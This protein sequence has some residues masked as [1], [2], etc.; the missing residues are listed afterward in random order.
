ACAIS[1]SISSAPTRSAPAKSRTLPG[2][3]CRSSPTCARSL[4]R[5]DRARAVQFGDL[6][7]REAP[8][9]Q[10][11]VGVLADP[12]RRTLHPRRRPEKTRRGGGLRNAFDLD[13]ALPVHIV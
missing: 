10:D 2:R 9:A 12:R 5:G 4:S 8:V 11:R 7:G 6:A 1:F 13:K 3:S